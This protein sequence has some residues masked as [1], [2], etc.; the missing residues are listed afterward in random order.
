[1][2]FMGPT[3]FKAMRSR[4]WHTFIHEMTR[5]WQGHNNDWYDIDHL[6]AGSPRYPY[7]KD[8]I[9][10]PPD[11]PGH[12]SAVGL[13]VEVLLGFFG[14]SCEKMRPTRAPG[15]IPRRGRPFTPA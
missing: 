2:L 1:M 14:R 7:I 11:V 5:L 4:E 9:R 12:I 6:S 8:Y 3:I 10:M 13:G 15:G